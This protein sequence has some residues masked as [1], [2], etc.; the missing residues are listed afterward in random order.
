MN[1]KISDYYMEQAV[2]DVQQT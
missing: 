1:N 2:F